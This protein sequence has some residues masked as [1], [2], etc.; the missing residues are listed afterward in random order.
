M[1]TREKLMQKITACLWFDN[2]A[3]EAA[4]LLRRDLRRQGRQ[5]IADQTDRAVW[6]GG[7]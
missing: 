3:E 7:S 6:R 1:S 5:E 2:E 4:K